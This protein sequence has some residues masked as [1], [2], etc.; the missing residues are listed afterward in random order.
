MSRAAIW[1]VVMLIL[2]L[3]PI[4]LGFLHAALTKNKSKFYITHIFLCY[5]TLI[6]IGFEGTFFGFHQIFQGNV[7]AKFIGWTWS[8]FIREVGMAN[9]SYGIL[10]LLSFWRDNLF[11]LA[12]IIGSCLFLSFAYVGHMYDIITTENFHPGN[13]GV[14]FF[15]DIFIPIIF[16]I[17]LIIHYREA[18]NEP[19]SINKQI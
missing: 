3:L 7:V 15:T 19:A 5:C 6:Y 12:T 16:A 17:L 9:L 13:A 11:R 8:P 4:G 2:F 18:R 1:Q 10:A 14:I